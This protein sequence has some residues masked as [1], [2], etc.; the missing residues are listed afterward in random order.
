MGKIMKMLIAYASVHGSTAEVALFLK[1][2]FSVYDAE[3]TVSAV[4]Q[5]TSVAGYDAFI[6]GTPISDGMWLRE[7]LEFADR[8]RDELAQ[9]P[10]Y[11]W[12]SCIRVLESDGYEHA[13]Q[14]YI[15]QP[16]LDAL[17]VQDVAVF[18]GRLKLENI[19]W[20]ERWMLSLRYDGAKRPAFLNKDF[21]NWEAIAAWGNKIAHKLELKP[22][23]AAESLLTTS[24]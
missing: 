9:K 21:R 15:H 5:V 24:H 2:V 7:L 8:F 10:C 22:S 1:R 14:N 17:K 23:F 20:E 19:N 16:T 12:I 18:A 13:R 4:D 11:F 6:L 3:V